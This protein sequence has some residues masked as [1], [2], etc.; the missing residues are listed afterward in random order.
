MYID[1][2]DRVTIKSILGSVTRSS[3]K[4]ID[5]ELTKLVQ[6]VLDV[7]TTDEDRARLAAMKAR[8]VE[9]RSGAIH[10]SEDL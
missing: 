3:L 1:E 8:L 9:V 7:F 4:I 2:S 10:H 6:D 5:P